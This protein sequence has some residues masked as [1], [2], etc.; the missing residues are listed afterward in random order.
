[1][2]SPVG[3]GMESGSHSR[4]DRE[5]WTDFKQRSDMM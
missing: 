5:L 1:M 3:P 4:R 2:S